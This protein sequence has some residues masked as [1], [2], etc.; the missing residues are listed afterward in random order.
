MWLV[1]V[2]GL[3]KVLG[4]APKGLPLDFF[5]SKT[6]WNYTTR[7]EVFSSPAVRGDVVYVGSNDK[8]FYALNAST[9]YQIWNHS[10]NHVIISSPVLSPKGDVVYVGSNDKKF[11]ALN[12]ST[13][14]QL[15]SLH[16]GDRVRSSPVLSP[17]GDVVYVGSDDKSLYALNT[18]GDNNNDKVR[19]VLA[20]LIG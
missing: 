8:K 3:V 11:Y 4:L 20:K 6:L 16:A 10:M 17:S 13:G 15:W 9:G 12:T 1:R 19:V 2:L 5:G 7:G 14:N 18:T